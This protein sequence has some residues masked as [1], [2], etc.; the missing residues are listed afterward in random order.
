MTARLLLLVTL[1][2][3]LSMGGLQ[4]QEAVP[5]LVPPTLVPTPVRPVN[6]SLPTE[7]AVARIVRDQRVRVG[8]LYNEPPFGELTVSQ[9]V[10]GFDA[11]LARAMAKLWDVDVEL[12]Q[13]TRQSGL[14]AVREGTVDLL[15]AAQV[16]RREFDSEVEFSLPYRISQ[17]SVMVRADDEAES[18]LNLTNR[19]LGYVLGTDAEQ[20]LTSWQ[21]RTGI[22]LTTQPYLTLDT[23]LASLFGGE[24]DGV[25]GRNEELLRVAGDQVFSAKV[26]DD[27]VEQEPF[28]IALL[29]QDVNLRNLVDRTLQFLVKD[30]TMKALYTTYFGGQAIAEDTLPLYVGLGDDAPRPDQFGTD[31]RFPAQYAVPRILQNRVVRVAGLVPPADDASDADRR[32]YELNRQLAEQMA[33]R[34]GVQLEIVPGGDV[35]EVLEQGL[36]DMAVGV[37]LDWAYASRVDF[38][39]PYALHGDRLMVEANG[40]I[41]GF[42]DLRGKWVGIMNTDTGAQDRA[43]AWAD[44]ISVRVRFYSVFEQNAAAAMLDEDNA[45]VT[46][47]DSLKLLQ[48]LNARPD[49][50]K[51]TDRWYSR[52]YFALAVPRNDVDMRLLV[53]YTLQEM[54]IDGSLDALLPL[55]LPANSEMPRFLVQPGNR[56]F[57]GLRLTR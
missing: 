34:W 28:A 10:R 53:N 56:D 8:V 57:M 36:A 7:S 39:Q 14:D 26:L 45:D 6:D 4:A 31:I 27:A 32:L 5:T 48:H 15:M 17:Q 23:A 30:E 24:V 50:L 16:D 47:G 19:R 51:L 12:I 29:R 54:V 41:A 52:D 44:S 40:Q 38:S 21:A 2:W 22:T 42:N 43:Q 18:L 3:A 55:I 37:T 49:D 20:A 46:Y 33:A 11:D 13:V 35:F 25:V 9:Q 1:L